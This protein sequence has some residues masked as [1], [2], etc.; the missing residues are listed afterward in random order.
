MFPLNT[1]FDFMDGIHFDKGCFIG[2]EVN[3]RANFTGLVH[4]RMCVFVAVDNKLDEKEIVAADDNR[5]ALARHVN[6]DSQIQVE[7]VTIKNARGLK[8][9]LLTST[10]IRKLRQYSCWSLQVWKRRLR[11]LR[12]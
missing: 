5:I 12:A 10:L 6:F 2:Q 9:L 3:A 11:E 7:G 1:N 4:K 8:T